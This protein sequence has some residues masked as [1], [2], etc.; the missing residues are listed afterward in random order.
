MPRHALL[1]KGLKGHKASA[2]SKGPGSTTNGFTSFSGVVSSELPDGWQ[3][4]RL[5]EL[6]ERPQYGLTASAT[7]EPKGPRFLR[8]TD[9]QESRVA[10]R[11]V[12]YCECDMD[13]AER[14]RLR[15]GD[16]VV[17]R[18]GATTGKAYLIR[19]EVDAVFASYLIRLRAT[20]RLVP[21]FLAFFTNS[22][23]YCRQIDS[24]KGGRLKQG[25]NIPLLESLEIPLPPLAEQQAIAEVLRTVQRAKEATEKVIAATRQLKASLMK[26]LFTY[27]PVPLEQ[28]DRVLLKETGLGPIPDHWR[29]ERLGDYLA[30]IR[31]GLTKPQN[32]EG[33]G[34]PVTRIETISE[35]KIN[36]AKVGCVEGLSEETVKKYRFQA[37]DILFSHINSEPQLGRT[38]MYVGQPPL[39]LHGMNLLL[40][41]A[42]SG[43]DPA[44]LHFTCVSLRSKGVFIGL[45]ARAVGQSSINMGKLKA[46]QIPIPP[47]DEQK[48]IAFWLSRVEGKLEA[49]ENDMTALGVLFKTLLHHLMTGKIR[50]THFAEAN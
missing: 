10:W 23:P 28:A 35:D 37:N 41:R 18:I 40:L 43:I 12:P 38:A 33:L 5:G 45:A 21:D 9:I 22:A 16:V 26:H 31:N 14:L 7:G 42:N 17:A 1:T 29:F 50:V 4:R 6:V 32:K 27:G 25:I 39:L 34:L 46:L 11:T 2:Q 15:P 3:L 44:F 8:I 36:P 47:K 48:R 20:D 24:V 19:D 13:S 49:E 30:L